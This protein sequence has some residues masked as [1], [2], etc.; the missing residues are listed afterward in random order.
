[1]DFLKTLML[2][3]TLTF[4]TS[5]Q[6]APPPQET[7]VPTQAPTVIVSPAPGTSAA[8][9]TLPPSAAPDAPTTAPTPE[10][11][12]TITPNAAYRN[13]EINDR[14]ASVRKLQER[15]I[16]L[17]YLTGE[18]DGAFGRQTYRA[19]RAFQT[20]NGL[21]ADGVAG[22]RTQTIL[23]ES[24]D[25]VAAPTV[26]PAVDE[27]PTIAPPQATSA[28]PAMEPETTSDGIISTPTDVA[29]P[30]APTLLQGAAIV[31]NDSGEKLTCLRQEDGVTIRVAPRVWRLEERILLDLSDL[32]ASVDA[33][34]LAQE[35]AVDTLTAEGYTVVLTLNDT[36][37][38]CRVD[39][40]PLVLEP[41]D[42]LRQDGQVLV[43][44]SLLERALNAQTEWDDEEATLMLRVQHKDVAQATD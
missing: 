41:L 21:V 2:Y 14:G 20:A 13:I 6:G 4:A 18:A 33:W 12:P 1:M 29:V 22:Q 40:V 43:S 39:D 15:L 8:P 34:N 9:V 24:P 44:A 30:P 19:L 16:E 32:A 36:A 28:L 42:V 31:L 35:G 23:Y 7:P 38:V 3:M 17:G 37:A 26:T 11:K 27:A 25:V 10:P 5:V